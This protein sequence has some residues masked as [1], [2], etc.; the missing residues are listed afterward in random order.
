MDKDMETEGMNPAL[1]RPAVADAMVTE[2]CAAGVA[3]WSV[4][5]ELVR[6]AM[7]LPTEA[8]RQRLQAW[9]RLAPHAVSMTTEYAA[10]DYLLTVGGVGAFARKDLVAIKAKQKSG[11]SVL[12][13]LCM[14]A[15]LGGRWSSMERTRPGLR[16]LY[17]DTEMKEADTQLLGRKALR[18]AGLPEGADVPELVMMN[19]RRLT[20]TECREALPVLLGELRPD[21]AFVDGIV[22]MVSDFN[23]VEESQ[24]VVRSLLDMADQYDCCLVSVLHTNKSADDHNMRGHLGTILSQKSANV[25][26]CEKDLKTNI[27][28]VKCVDFRHAPITDFSFGFDGQGHP[29]CAADVVARLEAETLAAREQRRHE[30]TEQRDAPVRAFIADTIRQHGGRMLQAEL[31]RLMA[32]AGLYR[33]SAARRF[34]EKMRGSFLVATKAPGST[35]CYL[36]LR[37]EERDDNQQEMSFLDGRAE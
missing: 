18:V 16:I 1:M 33:Q 36:M 25:F 24:Q 7:T 22:D 2:S 26:E 23:D 34:L 29:V 14:G 10:D 21:I 9:E 5:D 15:L 30:R 13:S 3:D 12:I 35:S 31:V 17:V 20:T 28:T 37:G 32:E 4:A 6:Q 19:L 27:V 8:E 11:K